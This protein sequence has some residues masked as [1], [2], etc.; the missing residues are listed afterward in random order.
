[1][2]VR[3]NSPPFQWWAADSGKSTTLHLNQL[4][5]AVTNLQI[6]RE[7]MADVDMSLEDV[8]TF[9]ICLGKQVQCMCIH[10]ASER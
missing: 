6:A 5:A 4:D 8:T 1:M 7:T 9:N 10:A 2:R 3:E